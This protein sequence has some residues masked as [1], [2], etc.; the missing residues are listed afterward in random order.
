MLTV[1]IFLSWALPDGSSQRSGLK[2][3]ASSPQMEVSLC[4]AQGLTLMMVYKEY[5]LQQEIA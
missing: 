2:V 3:S 5:Q 4:I 1:M